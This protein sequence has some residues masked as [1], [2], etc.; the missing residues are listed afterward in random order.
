[1]QFEKLICCYFS[2]KFKRFGLFSFMIFFAALKNL[3]LTQIFA[4]DNHFIIMILKNMIIIKKI[5]KSFIG[6]SYDKKNYFTAHNILL[7]QHH[8]F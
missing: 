3:L 5:Y 4:Q 6:K 2:N 8:D 1:M 7:M